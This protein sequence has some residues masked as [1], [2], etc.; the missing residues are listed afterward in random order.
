MINF[1]TLIDY[2]SFYLVKPGDN[3]WKIA[4]KFEITNYGI[5]QFSN[6][7]IQINPY[8]NTQKRKVPGD[9][10]I[11]GDVIMLGTPKYTY[12]KFQLGMRP[13]PMVLMNDFKKRD[14]ARII[15]RDRLDN[16][17]NKNDFYINNFFRYIGLTNNGASGIDLERLPF[18][19][20]RLR[21]AVNN[22]KK[23]VSNSI[24]L[25][26]KGR[27]S[28][29]SFKTE[30][31]K[32]MKMIGEKAGEGF[33]NLYTS[34]KKSMRATRFHVGNHAKKTFNKNII[35]LPK[36][37]RK[38]VDNGNRVMNR[39]MNKNFGWMKRGTRTIFW[40]TLA[41]DISLRTR[42]ILNTEKGKG[43]RE[44]F[45]QSCGLVSALGTG[46]GIGVICG[47]IGAL[48]YGYGFLPCSFTLAPRG[49]EIMDNLAKDVCGK[50]YDGYLND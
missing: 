44:S 47:G 23:F 10:L 22:Y 37:N 7:L 43:I 48:S 13:H 50:I 15:K 11:P 8:L 19:S 30:H 31:T 27:L 46:H 12:K 40:A 6:Y 25:I 34:Y 35:Q 2:E 18:K 20:Y 21:E 14:A 45:V 36:N 5:Q 41:I 49:I 4:S 29:H 1:D 24:E 16:P 42:E 26:E 3:L 17:Q 32:Y 38:I 33:K 9:L 28:Q 39:S